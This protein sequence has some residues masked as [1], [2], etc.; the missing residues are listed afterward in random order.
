MLY[1]KLFYHQTKVL[2]ILDNYPLNE[3]NEFLKFRNK[4]SNMLLKLRRTLLDRQIFWIFSYQEN[5]FA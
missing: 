2:L 1:K 3:I 5:Q 4:F